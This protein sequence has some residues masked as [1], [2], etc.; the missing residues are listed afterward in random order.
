MRREA[1][2]IST[3]PEIL[4]LAELKP[5][6][7]MATLEAQYQC[8]NGFD[9]PSLE[10]SIARHGSSIRAVLTTGGRGAGVG[11][12][13]RL[14]AL[15]LI[16]VYGVGVDAVDL[17]A[18]RRRGVRVTNT[19]DVLT[20]DVADFAIGLYLSCL[21]LITAG[22]RAVR[23]GLWSKPLEATLPRSARRRKVGIVGMGRIG[24]AIARRLT[25]FDAEI[26]YCQR[27]P[28]AGHAC[29]RYS[30]S[31][32]TGRSERCAVRVGPGRR[33]DAGPDRPGCDRGA[34]AA[35]TDR[36]HFSWQRHRRA[37]IMSSPGGR[38]IGW[39][40]ARRVC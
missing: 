20:D 18:A 5:K 35:G 37:G 4:V 17:E 40:S 13:D 3:A 23:A 16:A 24:S 10:A 11:L 14:P 31:G 32:G 22:D 12:I 19:P 38:D 28:A 29:K 2:A 30:S 36:Q 34:W 6:G 33:G 27:R 21:R 9:E 15:E 1:D 39:R 25:V 8:R 7:V 26:G